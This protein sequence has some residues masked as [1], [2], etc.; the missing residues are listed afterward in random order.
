M[1]TSGKLLSSVSI[2]I[3]LAATP[4]HAQDEQ[5]ELAQEL[6]QLKQSL[7]E[8]R[9]AI[10]QIETR[11]ARIEGRDA[12]ADGAIDEVDRVAETEELLALADKG[13]RKRPD[14]TTE[15]GK[16]APVLER[17]CNA[18]EIPRGPAEAEPFRQKD[19]VAAIGKT[20][21]A[22]FTPQFVFGNSSRAS[23]EIAHSWYGRGV[24]GDSFSPS[25]W[26][27]FGKLNAPLD[28][29]GAGTFLSQEEDD[30]IDYINGTSGTL[31]VQY[32]R[33]KPRKFS[34]VRTAVAKNIVSKNRESCL[35][36]N[37]FHTN[38]CEG[39]ALADYAS[40]LKIDDSVPGTRT[41]KASEAALV[42]ESINAF[43]RPATPTEVPLW[44]IKGSVTYGNSDFDAYDMD[45]MFT[46]IVEQ[47]GINSLEPIML[48][49][50]ISDPDRTLIDTDFD[51]SLNDWLVQLGLF[52]SVGPFILGGEISHKIFHQYRDGASIQL[53]VPTEI[54]DEL[55]IQDC[56]QRYIEKPR[57][58]DRTTLSGSL[59]YA[60]K[61]DFAPR[62]ALA[63][64]IAHTFQNDRW[65]FDFPLYVSDKD[66]KMSAGVRVRYDTGGL[67]LLQNEQ[68]N[69]LEF[70]VIFTP[71]T[72]SPF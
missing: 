17:F 67:D 50:L 71:F 39:Q 52:R 66:D 51:E 34:D 14:G 59:K 32:V 61:W 72:W 54:S 63:P 13:E 45:G 25:R 36:A 6:A 64:R 20:N 10:A 22:T 44:G 49:M 53:C 2:A 1:K 33:Y 41:L 46:R 9:A 21:L 8:S 16:E 60:W 70:S 68:K 40:R 11:I 62:L 15:I 28:K 43:W 3:A 26:T 4:A 38:K 58:I 31:G 12:S 24:V 65:I 37:G 56:K 18:L 7:T 55:E 42:A 27:L 30:D 23:M 5:A 57:D 19:C 29:D 35:L 48:N 47:D 69:D